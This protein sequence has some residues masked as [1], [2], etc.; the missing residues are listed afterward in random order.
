PSLEPHSGAHGGDEQ[1]LRG[2]FPMMLDLHPLGTD[3]RL[4][5]AGTPDLDAHISSHGPVPWQGGQGCL[6]GEIRRSGMTG[7]GGAGFP[8]ERKLAAVALGRRPVVVANGAE[9]EPTS[10]KDRVL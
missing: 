3:A 7:R 8:T 9:G 4:L 10:A 5:L 6:F 1:Q 2:G